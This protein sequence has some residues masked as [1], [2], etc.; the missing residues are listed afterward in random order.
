MKKIKRDGQVVGPRPRSSPATLLSCDGINKSFGNTKKAA[1]SASGEGSFIRLSDNLAP[2]PVLNTMEA[3]KGEQLNKKGKTAI[4]LT[5]LPATQRLDGTVYPKAPRHAAYSWLMGRLRD[6]MCKEN[7]STLARHNGTESV[8]TMSR[9]LA[10][11]RRWTGN[12]DGLRSMT[13]AEPKTTRPSGRRCCA[14]GIGCSRRRRRKTRRPSS[15]PT[16][17]R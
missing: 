12:E 7:Q 13:M 15:P 10:C 14:R 4:T 6:N 17:R 8:A 3:M 9:V 16:R 5:M 11:D 2:G 1:A